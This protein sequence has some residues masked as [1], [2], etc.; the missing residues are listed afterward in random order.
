MLTRCRILCAYV[1]SERPRMPAPTDTLAGF[2]RKTL[3]PH[4]ELLILPVCGYRGLSIIASAPESL[5]RDEY[6]HRERCAPHA[7]RAP[8]VASNQKNEVTL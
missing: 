7:G 5:N 6:E 1:H 3:S 2:I 8:S 4:P